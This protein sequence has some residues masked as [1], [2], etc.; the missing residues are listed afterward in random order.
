[1][2]IPSPRI[3]ILLTGL[4]AGLLLTAFD[5]FAGN[6]YWKGVGVDSNW[7]TVANWSTGGVPTAVDT[8]V[9][10]SL[11]PG[12]NN[13]MVEITQPGAVCTNFY[14]GYDANRTG[15]V[16]MSG[17]DLTINYSGNRC[18]F[19]GNGNPSYGHFIQ[20]GGVV[21][22]KVSSNGG[23]SL[24]F[25]AGS[26]GLYELNGGLL[27]FG[28]IEFANNGPGTFIQNAGSTC[29]VGSIS[30]SRSQGSYTMN[31]GVLNAGG[32]T[33]G[34]VAGSSCQ[35]IQTGGTNTT[36][37]ID[38]SGSGITNKYRLA[39]ATLIVTNNG[40]GSFNFH[41]KGV[42]ELAAGGLIN[43]SGSD[44]R[45][46]VGRDGGATLESKL[47]MQGGRITGTAYFGVRAQYAGDKASLQ[48]WGNIDLSLGFYN[49]G[50]IIADGF[51]A[52]QTLAITNYSSLSQTFAN[53]ITETN[54]WYA[55]NKG[56]LLLKTIAVSG[57]SPVLY[58]GEPSSGA[59]DLVNAVKLSLSGASGSGTLS[60][61]LYARDHS[62]VP[63][64]TSGVNLVSLWNFATNG[65]SM[66]SGNVMFRYDSFRT[67]NTLAMSENDLRVY[68]H[69]GTSW[70]KVPIVGIDTVNK[71]I[72]A[73]NVT[74]L[75]WF[76]VA[77]SMA[78]IP[79]V[80]DAGTNQSIKLP[81][82]ASLQGT[83]TD[84]GLPSGVLT[85]T[86]SQ[87]S[88]PAGVTF[89]NS[90]S[91][92]TTADFSTGGAGTYVLRLTATDGDLVRS[93]VMTTTVAAASGNTTPT[94]SAGTYQTV[95]IRAPA[96]LNGSVTDDG[97][98][99]GVTNI[100]WSQ[101][102]GPGTV[103]FGNPALTNT[104]AAFSA[105]GTYVLQLWAS[106]TS[107]ASSNTVTITVS[108]PSLNVYWDQGG[109]DSTWA[110]AT[111]WTGDVVP[112]SMDMAYI[113]AASPGTNIAVAQITQSGATC[114]NLCL[115]NNNNTTGTVTITGGDLT[116]NYSGNRCMYLG[117]G[118][119]SYGHFIQTGGVVSNKGSNGG[120]SLGVGIGG[121][122]TYEL[123]GGLL[124]FGYIEVGNYGNG[125][126]IQNAG[127]TC[128]VGSLSFC[129]YNYQGA[130]VMSGGVLNAGG[131][132]LNAGNGANSFSQ[133]IQT[134]GTN[135]SGA[136]ILNGPNGPGVTNKY[137]LAGGTLIITNADDTMTINNNGLLEMA[138][139]GELVC[140][141]GTIYVGRYNGDASEGRILMRGGRMSGTGN[142]S[143]RG[144]YSM[145]Q[146]TL[147]GWGTVDLSGAFSMAGRT[148]AD[149]FG[150]DQ[151]L[152]I[153]NYR[154]FG[155]SYANGAAETNGWYAQNHGKLLLKSIPVTASV[156][157]TNVYWGGVP[158]LSNLVNAIK[159]SFTNTTGAGSISGSLY[160][161][162]HTAIPK[163]TP[164]SSKVLAIW[165]FN[166]T[167][168][169]FA[170]ATLTFRYDA[171]NAVNQGIQ[172]AN[173]KVYQHNGDRWLPA[174]T[175]SV[176][177]GS[178]TI[179]ASNLTALGFFGVAETIQSLSPG[180]IMTVR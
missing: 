57:A 177:P 54:G 162:N 37:A 9:I 85:T 52:D 20:N 100:L 87:V 139:G 164:G 157:V 151:T 23:L 135:T 114:S 91:L 60:G 171:T 35:F 34:G 42:F 31:G 117:N 109:A 29:T 138:Q 132:T 172:E 4:M 137:R 75:G 105:D 116:V 83:A 174:T 129:Q 17:G 168:F 161:T 169:T 81:A 145:N 14:L 71:L 179:V 123:N 93:D 120:M 45:I 15:T 47:L 119:L 73:S 39:N 51:G 24:G 53:S 66:G 148:I 74:S 22:N 180:T 77:E 32:I 16:T 82:T 19:L 13:A 144:Q 46:W 58:W 163:Y 86:W 136:L 84:D 170:S 56:R 127:S 63:A 38:I 8:P 48:G 64:Y 152:A 104:T 140:T 133:F 108:T 147:Q 153:T 110:N 102:S 158:S 30:F 10:G 25:G 98:P 40:D 44:G 21:S 125:M 111:N 72:T 59:F 122:G 150:A 36:G 146:G 134:G 126:F 131:I 166:A 92:S 65:F 7:T 2:K 79:P 141:P 69:N 160:A 89:G 124:Q 88:G 165:E 68:Q 70:V 154:S 62:Q 107:L 143:V 43:M 178:K 11:S 61:S 67:T 28:Y 106:D 156:T 142:L 18:M 121:A 76:S 112:L 115:G 118:N 26:S 101:Y 5:A 3:P 97:L 176:N 33:V 50:L 95:T 155:Q 113:G 41:Q 167:N 1:V 80:V 130:Y 27:T 173:L 49:A 78:N 99:S 175:F 128:N 55:Q 90:N 12:T 159:L 94:V 149:G 96:T 103:T 6:N